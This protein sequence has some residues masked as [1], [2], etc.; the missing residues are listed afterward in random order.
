MSRTIHGIRIAGIAVQEGVSERT[1]R[2]KMA[3]YY[4]VKDVQRAFRR[5][6]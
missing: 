5:K 4:R 3:E 6:K 1:A 2:R